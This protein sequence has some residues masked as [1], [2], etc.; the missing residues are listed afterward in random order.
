MK[1]RSLIVVK[2][3][4]ASFESEDNAKLFRESLEEFILNKRI[5][6]VHKNPDRFLGGGVGEKEKFTYEICKVEDDL[7]EN[8]ETL[9]RRFNGERSC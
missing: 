5:A 6:H 8:I 3:I 9:I 1:F 7:V 4:K 2:K